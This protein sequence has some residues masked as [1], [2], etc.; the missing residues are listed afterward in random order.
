MSSD[1]SCVRED[2]V[3]PDTLSNCKPR[4]DIGLRKKVSP[5]NINVSIS[6][7]KDLKFCNVI[8]LIAYTCTYKY[9]CITLY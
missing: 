1:R 5:Q 4:F 2:R 3:Y 7:N 9:I 8:T 6:H